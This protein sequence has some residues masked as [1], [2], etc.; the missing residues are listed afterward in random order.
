[1][2][3]S[4]VHERWLQRLR[5][6]PRPVARMICF[7]HAGGSASSFATLAR[8]VDGPLEVFAVQSPG[9]Q[10]RRTEPC[11]ETVAE[12]AAG[13]LPAVLEH[14][15][16]PI[17]LFGHSLGAVVAFEVARL[18]EAE[19]VVPR[20]LF[21]SGRRAPS[22]MR[23]ESVHRRSDAG[24]ITELRLLGGPGVE[25]LDDP[26]IAAAFLPAIRSDYR[27]V[28]TYRPEPDARVRCPV[29]VLVGD[30]DPRVSRAEAEAWQSHASGA[31][32]LR[33]FPGGHFY[34]WDRLADVVA[35][36]QRELVV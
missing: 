18:M 24:I 19:G 20:H 28:E 11:L 9:R 26:E 30:R 27:A 15:E 23:Y 8:A 17:A 13:A 1:M 16:L 34:L 7:A 2:T 6:H 21:V 33:E 14:R 35:A 36:V 3:E 29:T 4:T 10:D 31:F 22:A 32:E 25:M 5:P 12:L